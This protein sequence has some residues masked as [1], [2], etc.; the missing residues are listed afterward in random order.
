MARAKKWE[1]LKGILP[2]RPLEVDGPDVRLQAGGLLDRADR[3]ALL[4]VGQALVDAA[5]YT[6][7]TVAPKSADELINRF[8]TVRNLKSAIAAAEKIIGKSKSSLNRDLLNKLEEWGMASFGNDG[9]TVSSSG[10]PFPTVDNHDK[11]NKWLDEND[12]GHMRKIG[13]GDLNGLVVDH[14]EN[15]KGTIPGVK[16][17]FDE[18]VS[19]R[20]KG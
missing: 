1:H 14:L 17:Y 9:F 7:F 6:T 11:L 13:K 20:K 4:V 18:T 2:P 3:D 8:V 10:K 16:V 15:G 12:C 19:V 5:T